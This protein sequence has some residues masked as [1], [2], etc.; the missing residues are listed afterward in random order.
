MMNLHDL[1]FP[2]EIW[3]NRWRKRVGELKNIYIILVGKPERIDY[4]GRPT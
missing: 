4:F 3:V 1:D 2:S